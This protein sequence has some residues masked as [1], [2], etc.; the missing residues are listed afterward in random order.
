M[1]NNT[2]CIF[3]D[4]GCD[5]SPTLLAE[6]GV[7][8]APLTF[9]F[10][11]SE[12]EYTSGEMSISE[13]YQKMRA[14]L[15]AKTAAV[16]TEDF[17]ALFETALTEGKDVLYIGLSS[18]ISNTYNAARLAAIALREKYPERKIYTVDSLCASAGQGLLVYFAA[19]KAKESATVEETAQYIEGLRL[20]LCHWFTVEDLVYLK[21]GGRVS[22]T[23]AFVGNMLGIKPVMH[24]DNDGKL[25]PVVKARGRK[26]AIAMLAEKYKE[27][28]TKPASGQV[29]I[30]Q[31]D[32]ENEAKE[33]ARILR[34]QNG[35]EVAL[36]TDISPVIGAHAGPGTIALFFVGNER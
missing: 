9:R 14:G 30:S 13:F 24:V 29:F 19:Q 36:I 31:A 5:I 8:C 23:T 7:Q 10:N 17:T 22:A 3:T 34:E 20:N 1:Q 6:W 4:S 2:F 11:D 18:G 12:K 25:V 35:V 21:R 26:K 27:L 32:C 16:N 15:I 33:L 28:A